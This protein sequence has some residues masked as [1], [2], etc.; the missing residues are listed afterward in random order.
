MKL[1]TYK[2]WTVDY[3]LS[4]FRRIR[5]SGMIDFVE[6]DSDKG[7]KILCQMIDDGV[8]DYTKWQP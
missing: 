8:I 2:G 6:F 5:K 7:D 1:Q 4:Q 3:R